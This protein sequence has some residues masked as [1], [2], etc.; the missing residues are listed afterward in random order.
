MFHRTALKTSQKLNALAN[1][2]LPLVGLEPSMTLA[3][4]GEYAKVAGEGSSEPTPSVL[5]IQEWLA[6][7]CDHLEKQQTN[8]S[9]TYQLLAH[10]TE[11]TNASSSINDWKRVFSALGHTLNTIDV[12]CCGM[13]G[14][15]GHE[16]QNIDMSKHI[17]SLS[18]SEVVNNPKNNDNLVASGFS[19]LVK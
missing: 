7:H 8:T 11:K 13:A 10:C 15:Y 2:G 16:T 6:Q 5:L 19:C 4:R 14:T 17:Y 18:W 3:Y 12:G 9:N 1:T